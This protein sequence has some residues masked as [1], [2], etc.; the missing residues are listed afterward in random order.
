MTLAGCQPV[1]SALQGTEAA[2]TAAAPASAPA[3]HGKH[4]LLAISGYNY[5]DRIIDGFS[6]NG[7][8]GGNIPLTVRSSR[9]SGSV[10]C[11]G[12]LDGSALPRKVTVQWVSGYCMRPHKLDGDK[13]LIRELLWSITEATLEGP[14]PQDP[15]NFEVHFYRNGRVEVAITH[16]SSLPRVLLDMTAD[17]ATR[18]GMTINDPPC[19]ADYS[20]FMAHLR[21]QRIDQASLKEP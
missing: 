15:K 20:G 13:T 7:Q 3:K 10:C 19:P 5:T 9:P 17:E 8:G 14:V 1:G 16:E 12:W 11:V 18:P 4:H 2:Q 6:V 21:P